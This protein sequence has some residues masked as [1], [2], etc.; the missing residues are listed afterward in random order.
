[1]KTDYF[2]NFFCLDIETHAKKHPTQIIH[3][4]IQLYATKN[5][6]EGNVN[7]VDIVSEGW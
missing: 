3:S 4:V 2:F 6:K 5:D 7:I 1:M